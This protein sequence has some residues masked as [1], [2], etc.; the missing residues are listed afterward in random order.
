LEPREASQIYLAAIFGCLI[1]GPGS[2]RRHR[3]ELETLATLFLSDDRP[4]SEGR[5]SGTRR[6]RST[7]T[8][9]RSALRGGVP[10]RP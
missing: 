5:G 4:G 3:G 6:G 8:Q 2:V 1:T 7:Q 10:K 9:K